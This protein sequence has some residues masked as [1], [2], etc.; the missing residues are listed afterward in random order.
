[1]DVPK[2]PSPCDVPLTH[3]LN[4]DTT[5]DIVLEA[6]ADVEYDTYCRQKRMLWKNT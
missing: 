6:L 1:M 3:T 4:T 5:L 2:L